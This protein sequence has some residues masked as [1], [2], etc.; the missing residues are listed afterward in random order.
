MITQ[1]I[2][3]LQAELLQT[4]AE[5]QE[6][7]R[8]VK[9]LDKKLGMALDNQEAEMRQVV[10]EARNQV[11]A[12]IMKYTRTIEDKD[13]EIC[14]QRDLIISLETRLAESELLVGELYANCSP[15]KQAEILNRDTR[16]PKA[17]SWPD[18]R[19]PTL[20][21]GPVES[22]PCLE[23]PSSVRAVRAEARLRSSRP[24]S[25]SGDE[26]HPHDYQRFA[27]GT[28]QVTTSSGDENIRGEVDREELRTVAVAQSLAPAVEM[29]DSSGDERRAAIADDPTRAYN[30]DSEAATAGS[31]DSDALPPGLIHLASLPFLESPNGRR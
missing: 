26:S 18:K 5:L 14:I 30:P 16:H 11:E 22:E 2:E 24:A 15:R 19:G 31:T 20:S 27:T 10:K 3:N 9:L 4:K 7:K 25:S 21:P 28:R 8:Q 23:V 1:M 29:V 17:E 12:V 13:A 6:Q